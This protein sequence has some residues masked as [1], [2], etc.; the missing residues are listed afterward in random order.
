MPSY[1][2]P[3]KKLAQEPAPPPAPS[4]KIVP[5]PTPAP[6]KPVERPQWTS[7]PVGPVVLDRRALKRR[8]EQEAL[9]DQH[10][11]RVQERRA[12]EAARLR[13]EEA[14]KLEAERREHAAAQRAEKRAR[15]DAQRKEELRRQFEALEAERIRDLG[16]LQQLLDLCQ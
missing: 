14:A 1:R 3:K 4:I 9:A 15:L 8:R 12:R 10:D 5:D 11:A 2:I 16:L 6:S 7:R 13:A